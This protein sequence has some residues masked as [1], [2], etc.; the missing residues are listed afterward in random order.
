M[1]KINWEEAYKKEC[2]SWREIATTLS[3]C[4]L[5]LDV[6]EAGECSFDEELYL[7]ALDLAEM[8]KTNKEASDE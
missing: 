5:M 8:F 1:S 2:T 7:K 6:Y 4:I 3:D